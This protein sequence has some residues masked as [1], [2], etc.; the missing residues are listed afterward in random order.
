MSAPP[1]G[2]EAAPLERGGRPP[3]L[4]ARPAPRR[5][6]QPPGRAPRNPWSSCILDGWGLRDDRDA[7]A[8]LLAETPTFDRIRATCPHAT[9]TTHGPD[10]GLPTGQMGN[11]EVGHTN[12][13]AGRVVAMDLRRASTSPSSD[14]P[15]R[16]EPGARRASSATVKAVGRHGAPRSG[17]PRPAA[18]TRHQR[19]LVAAATALIAAGAC[20]WRCTPS[21]TAAT[22]R[23]LGARGSARGARGGAAGGRADRHGH[24]PLLRDGPRQPL[25]AGARG[26]RRRSLRGEG[27]RAATR[28]RG[29]AAAY[30]RGET[31]E[32]VAPTVI[33]DYDGRRGRRRAVLRSTSAPT[34][35]ARSWRRSVD[36][37]FDGF[38]R[39]PAPGVGGACSG[40]S[41][42]RTRHDA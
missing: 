16:R 27:Q 7:N 33:G 14:G 23:R 38:D 35:R 15:L 32:F 1:A 31:D 5:A 40:W 19:H 17:W 42:I 41:S 2:A 34:A 29:V 30:A 24:G 12:I 13:G 39:R 18:C 10:V 8:P 21:P 36:P 6:R 26:L 3:S 22:C 4:P 25:G 37:A 20:R 9:L 28:G 11:S